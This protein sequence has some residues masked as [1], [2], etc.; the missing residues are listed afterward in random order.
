MTG[1][2]L[3]CSYR[4]KTPAKTN[5]YQVKCGGVENDD[6]EAENE[7][8]LQSV[9]EKVMLLLFIGYDATACLTFIYDA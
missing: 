3:L 7:V 5:K 4:G 8:M 6:V 9:Q 1:V 2:S